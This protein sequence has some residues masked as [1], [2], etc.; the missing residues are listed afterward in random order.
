MRHF[1]IILTLLITIISSCELK[2]AKDYKFGVNYNAQRKIKGSPLV[3]QNM[4]S[5]YCC[6]EE[7]VFE[8]SKVPND[9]SAYHLSKSIRS[10]INGRLT[11]EK[12]IY[13]KNLND[14]TL[15]QL[16]ILTN[17]AL[18]KGKLTFKSNLGKIDR[19]TLN[20]KASEFIQKDS[21]YPEYKWVDLNLLQIDS[22]LASWHLSRFDTE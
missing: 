22:V 20:M 8:I 19:R 9:T 7:T 11:E 21:K 15:I 5:K 4:H 1:L 14:T 18:A 16:N 17:W 10:I 2:D 3:K 6:N 13:R 12:D